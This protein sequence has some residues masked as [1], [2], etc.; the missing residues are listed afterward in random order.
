M[1][2][3]SVDQEYVSRKL[4]KLP[5]DLEAMATKVEEWLRT[6]DTGP[7]AYS[8]IKSYDVFYRLESHYSAH[9]GFASF[10]RYLRASPDGTSDGVVALPS[11][12]MLLARSVPLAAA[13][14][15][16]LAWHV[17][18]ELG[19]STSEIDALL[20]PLAGEGGMLSDGGQHGPSRST[21]AWRSS[22]SPTA[23][24][25]RSGRRCA[26]TDLGEKP[27]RVQVA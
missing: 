19:L 8:T 22:S 11:S 9:A 5:P 25:P 26:F 24:R 15:A 7:V 18:R 6:A 17:H 23:T 14:V 4:G 27:V 13:Y 10:E 12:A 2:A 1:E 16:H 3:L 21:S 20:I